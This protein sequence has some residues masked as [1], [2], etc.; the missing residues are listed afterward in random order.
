[1]KAGIMARRSPLNPRYQRNTEPAGKTRRSASAAKPKREAGAP[2]V[3]AGK[4]AS[5]KKPSRPT[6]R[7][8]LRNVPTTPEIKRWQNLW[9]ISMAA[10]IGMLVL[11]LVVPVFRSNNQLGFAALVVYAAFLGAGLYIQLAKIRPLRDKAIAEAKAGKK[12]GKA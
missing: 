11:T 7:E 8:A 12:G 9:W 2:G 10:A 5:A 1:M 4:P 6:F 3:P